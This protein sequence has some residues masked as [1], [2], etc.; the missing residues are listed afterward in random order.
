MRTRK[1]T[2]LLCEFGY[3]MCVCVFK[4]ARCWFDSV[5]HTHTHN[6]VLHT[7]FGIYTF[8]CIFLIGRMIASELIIPSDVP[9]A[10]MCAVASRPERIYMFTANHQV[11][12]AADYNAD[13][14]IH[15]Y[16]SHTK[17]THTHSTYIQLA[18]AKKS[19]ARIRTK[20]HYAIVDNYSIQN[21]TVWVFEQIRD[22]AWRN[23]HFIIFRNLNKQTARSKPECVAHCLNHVLGLGDKFGFIYIEMVK[24]IRDLRNGWF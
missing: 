9:I 8:T 20:V 11:N 19:R 1:Q 10:M 4:A 15:I 22:K 3:M 18:R 7:L 24:R 6:G 21:H 12:P 17:H 23:V 16:S 2:F 13:V 14:F 5:K